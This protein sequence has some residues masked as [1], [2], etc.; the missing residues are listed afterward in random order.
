MAKPQNHATFIKSSGAIITISVLLLS[1]IV[2]CQVE[3]RYGVPEKYCFW[4][5]KLSVLSILLVLNNSEKKSEKKKSILESG[6]TVVQVSFT[7]QGVG[8]TREEMFFQFW[9]LFSPHVDFGASPHVVFALPL[10]L[11]F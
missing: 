10:I 8:G 3:A 2:Y 1:Y 4:P 11:L 7:V 5:Q 6:V 9:G